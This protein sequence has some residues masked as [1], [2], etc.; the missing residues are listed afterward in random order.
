MAQKQ[1]TIILNI[2][3][4]KTWRTALD[5]LDLAGELFDRLPEWMQAE[6]E[7]MKQRC[8]GLIES[9][10]AELQTQIERKAK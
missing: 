9:V 7:E 1:V 8:A 2:R 10:T 5:V 4:G 3:T 6:R